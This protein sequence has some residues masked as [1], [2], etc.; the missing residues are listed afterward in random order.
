MGACPE[1]VSD[2]S[3]LGL[4]MPTLNLI[5]YTIMRKGIRYPLTIPIR[6]SDSTTCTISFLI[7]FSDIT[8][9][10]K[11]I[12]KYCIYGSEAQKIGEIMGYKDTYN[13]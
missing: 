11:D 5:S 2:R 13:R 7:L 3:G 12:T 4:C 8:R 6:L 1:F 10:P 9:I